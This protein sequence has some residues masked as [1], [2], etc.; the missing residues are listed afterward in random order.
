M[1]HVDKHCRKGDYCL[2]NLKDV[3]TRPFRGWS[4]VTS[5][6]GERKNTQPLTKLVLDHSLYERESWP[7]C[8]WWMQARLNNPSGSFLSNSLSAK[9]IQEKLMGLIMQC[10]LVPSASST[11]VQTTCAHRL[12]ARPPIF[13][14]LEKFLVDFLIQTLL[15]WRAGEK[16]KLKWGPMGLIKYTGISVLCFKECVSQLIRH[17]L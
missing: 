12:S 4:L 13:G 17:Q 10:Q 11:T 16:S 8:Q 1:H 3:N 7:G 6:M 9:K 2:P 15:A 5:V 14:L